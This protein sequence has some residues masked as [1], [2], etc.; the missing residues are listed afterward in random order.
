MANAPIKITAKFHK[1]RVRILIPVP[2]GDSTADDVFRGI[3]V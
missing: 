2:V 3:V 1:M